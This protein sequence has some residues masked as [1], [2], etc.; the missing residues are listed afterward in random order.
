MWVLI[1]FGGTHMKINQINECFDN[2][3]PPIQ[4]KSVVFLKINSLG[5]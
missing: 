2:I 4:D 5:C 1:K 3:I